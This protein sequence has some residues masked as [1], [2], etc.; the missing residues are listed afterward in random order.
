MTFGKK[1]EQDKEIE[2]KEALQTLD[3]AEEPKTVMPPSPNPPDM[4]TINR[5]EA[6]NFIIALENCVGDIQEQKE[7]VDKL[8][9]ERKNRQQELGRFQ[10]ET[11]QKFNA[12]IDA[13]NGLKEKLKTTESY[14]SYL[15]ERIN[16]ANL[17]KEVGMLETLLNKE[18]AE[19]SQ[20]LINTDNFLTKK[21]G[22]MD[23]K[24]GELHSA[25]SVIKENI[26]NFKEEIK[27]MF[28]QQSVK[29]NN[30]VAESSETI[31]KVSESNS[32]GLKAE[33]NEMIK[34]Y[35]EKCQENLQ[36]IQQQS[37][38]FLKQCSEQNKKLI[39]KVPAVAA[40]KFS[41]KD[42][43][44]FCMAA[45]SIASAAMQIIL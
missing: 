28:A 31:R 32:M 15:E 25:D 40:S 37:I 43:V 29:T 1:S 30:L 14:E 5:S 45:A 12:L 41:T 44:I 11:I 23:E 22:A 33:A 8:L 3:E 17:Q 35:T 9:E 27:A 6:E 21:I 2:E 18:K 13:T 36:K 7:L 39:E 26:D 42:I 4:V 19:F 10:T 34:A 24:I 38:D 20:F 16:N